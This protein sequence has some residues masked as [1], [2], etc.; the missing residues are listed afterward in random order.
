MHPLA[1]AGFDHWDWAVLA[2]Y[3]A[4]L[5]GSGVYF[6]MRQSKNTDDYF[7]A[8]HRMPVWA[9][10]FS[11]LATA[12]SAATFVGAP[13]SSYLGNLAY[14]S[15][16]IGGILA[17]ILLA[18]VFI[19]AYY[20]LGVTT[21]YQLLE[22]RFGSGAK[23]IA[24]L[25]Y[26]IGRVFAGGARLF[27]GALPFSYLVFGD[28]SLAHIALAVAMFTVFG[29]L[30]TLWGGVGSVIWT[31]VLQVTVYLG[32]TIAAVVVLRNLI[33][34][35][36]IDIIDALRHPISAAGEPLPSKLTLINPGLDFSKPFLGFDPSASISLLTV[37]FGFSLL[38]LASHGADQD[39][40]QRM[41][42]C[43]SPLKGSLSVIGGV[44]IGVPTV[45][46][47]L[48]FG[49]LLYIFYQ[50]PD[51]MGAAAPAAIPE[52][53]KL[54]MAFAVDHMPAGLAGL[55]LAGLLA[56]GPCGINASLNSMSSTFVSDI[57][58]PRRAEHDERHYLYIGRLAVVGAGIVVG[59]FAAA[60]HWLYDEA[61]TTLI[62]FAL[63]VMNFAYAGLLGV[64]ITALFSRRGSVRSCIAA[65]ITGFVS[66]WLMQPVVLRAA[67]PL[68]DT[69][70][71]AVFTPAHSLANVR[72]AFPW[73]L[74]IGTV[75]ATGVCLIGTRPPTAGR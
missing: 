34:V 28:T 66:V 23:T 61:N 65:I 12:Q 44:L 42:T 32:A 15:T 75:L 5:I 41:L 58:R 33:P 55:M 48:V 38:T 6:S 59:L 14:L 11:I 8:G 62:D 7:L 56:A 25:T 57:Y 35:G 50:R 49:L 54:V 21:P 19:P 60:C 51:I 18:T 17:A 36:T 10:A 73:Q 46:L 3:F 64:F 53:K 43:R 16:N 22:I 40:V 63:G 2:G 1:A 37:L 47:F 26:M 9:V 74:L 45:L 27:I 68:L 70:V 71:H 67:T 20:R 39:L 4:L 29:I 72:I 30:Y 24:S 69:V 52:S 13:E 31:D